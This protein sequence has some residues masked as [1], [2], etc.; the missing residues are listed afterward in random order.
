MFQKFFV[1][2]G[3]QFVPSEFP[4]LKENLQQVNAQLANWPSVTKT[5]MI[6]SFVKFHSIRSQ[7]VKDHPEL[8]ALISSR[9]LPLQLIEDLFASCKKNP[10]FSKQLEDYIRG[11]FVDKTL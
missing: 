2:D 11:C 10:L 7:E 5:E 4:P 3:D 6:I 1:G 8:A 9:S